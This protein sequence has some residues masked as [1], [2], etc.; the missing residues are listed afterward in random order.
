MQP[1]HIRKQQRTLEITDT[2]WSPN[3]GLSFKLQAELAT[4]RQLGQDAVR[5]TFILDVSL[6]PGDRSDLPNLRTT[7]AI[8][9]WR[10]K[11]RP[12]QGSVLI[13]TVSGKAITQIGER[14]PS[15][16][17]INLPAYAGWQPADYSGAWFLEG[18][19]MSSYQQDG[20]GLHINVDLPTMKTDA[21]EGGGITRR[22]KEP[23][24]ISGMGAVRVVWQS[25]QAHACKLVCAHF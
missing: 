2:V 3:G 12:M 1:S 21:G 16:R 13:G 15:E 11:D 24:D 5:E 10:R 6:Q 25:E 14:A 20:D 18:D 7:R 19:A 23:V 17:T 22:L 8:P 4:P 9:P